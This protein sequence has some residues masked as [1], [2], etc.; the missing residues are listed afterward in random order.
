MAID[1]S[2]LIS[3]ASTTTS[4]MSPMAMYKKLQ[5]VAEENSGANEAEQA[6]CLRAETNRHRY[7]SPLE[8][9]GQC[10]GNYHS[11]HPPSPVFHHSAASSASERTLRWPSICTRPLLMACSKP[12][13][14]YM[15]PVHTCSRFAPA[16]KFFSAGVIRVCANALMRP[17]FFMEVANWSAVLSRKNSIQKLGKVLRNT[18]VHF[19]VSMPKISEIHPLSFIDCS[20]SW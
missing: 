16:R 11:R 2:V 12:G 18:S 15:R 8:T 17:L 14:R 3:G 9:Y 1:L 4:T 13:P 10:Y 20:V 7:L 6:K 19:R 5:K